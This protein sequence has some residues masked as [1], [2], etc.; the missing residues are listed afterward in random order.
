MR[1]FLEFLA[2]AVGFSGWLCFFIQRAKA[3]KIYAAADRVGDFA[4]KQYD[5]WRA[6]ELEAGK[7]RGVA[8]F[9]VVCLW[10][11]ASVLIYRRWKNRP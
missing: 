6:A 2:F 9:C 7:W 11:V 4:A 3:Q 1:L 8:W 5:Q 10:L